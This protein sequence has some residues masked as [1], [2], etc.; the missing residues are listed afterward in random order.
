MKILIINELCKG[1][2][3]EVQTM[4]EKAILEKNGHAVLLIT[5]DP[6][7][8]DGWIDKTHWNISAPNGT[9]KRHIDLL[10][11]NRN[12]KNRLKEQIK[13]FSPDYIHLN[14]A[15]EHAPSIYHALEG[16]PCLRTVRDYGAVCPTSFSIQ[17]DRTVCPGFQNFKCCWK[18]CLGKKGGIL[19]KV[20]GLWNYACFAARTRGQKNAICQFACPSQML[21]NYCLAFGFKTICISNS[22]D[23]SIVDQQVTE[24]EKNNEK[25]SGKKIFLYYGQIAWF[26]GIEPLVDAFHEF[27]SGKEDV[28]LLIAGSVPEYEEEW[29]QNVQLRFNSKIHYLGKLDYQDMLE[30]LKT[31]H[32]VIVPSLWMENYPNTVLEAMAMGCLVLGSERGG[33][34]EMIGDDRFIFHVLE[35]K[36]IQNKMEV[37]YHMSQEE[38]DSITQKNRDRIRKNNSPDEYYAKLMKCLQ[39]MKNK[40]GK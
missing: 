12:I 26:K 7:F 27:S 35:K 14:N 36:D 33:M 22:F 20:K 24:T 4:R 39:A 10:C 25:F 16:Y 15:F 32:T 18:N 37:A 8:S 5:L 30:K 23:F 38:Y 21:T 11:C 19:G 34:R 40:S 2:G 31:V 17:E 1:G 6:R 3:A 28:E 29:F 9:V 13:A